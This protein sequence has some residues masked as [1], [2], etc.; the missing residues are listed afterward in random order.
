MP[1]Q[2][3]NKILDQQVT[4]SQTAITHLRKCVK[5]SNQQHM[6]ATRLTDKQVLI[7]RLSHTLPQ[8]PIASLAS[9]VKPIS[10]LALNVCIPNIYSPYIIKLHIG[11]YSLN[12]ESSEHKK[13]IAISITVQLSFYSAE[14]IIEQHELDQYDISTG[15][16]SYYDYGITAAIDDYIKINQ[17]I[18]VLNRIQPLSPNILSLIEDYYRFAYQFNKKYHNVETKLLLEGEQYPEF[19][20]ITKKYPRPQQYHTPYSEGNKLGNGVNQLLATDS[21]CFPYISTYHSPQ[22][23]E[24]FVLIK[25]VIDN[26]IEHVSNLL[27]ENI[28]LIYHPDM[29]GNLPIEIALTLEY[30]DITEILLKAHKYI[31]QNYCNLGEEYARYNWYKSRYK[32]LKTDLSI[33]SFFCFSR[34]PKTYSFQPFQPESPFHQAILIGDL[35]LVKALIQDNPN[36]I[37]EKSNLGFDALTV[38]VGNNHDEITKHLLQ[39]INKHKTKPTSYLN[40][41]MNISVNVLDTAQTAKMYRLLLSYKSEPNKTIP[42]LTTVERAL[43]SANNT[44]AEIIEVMLSYDVKDNR[45]E[46]GITAFETILYKLHGTPIKDDGHSFLRTLFNLF[47]QFCYV[48]NGI[49]MPEFLLA[50]IIMSDV[51]NHN[52]KLQRL[53][54]PSPQLQSIQYKYSEE[55]KMAYLET[56]MQGKANC[57]TFKCFPSASLYDE[58]GK[59]KEIGK[60][61]KQAFEQ[62]AFHIFETNYPGDS[63]FATYF[64]KSPDTEQSQQCTYIEIGLVNNIIK[65]LFSFTIFFQENKL[66]TRLDH[67]FAPPRFEVSNLPFFSYRWVLALADKYPHLENITVAEL[68]APGYAYRYFLNETNF[69]PKYNIIYDIPKIFKI[70]QITDV[71]ENGIKPA[72]VSVTSRPVQHATAFPK[73]IEMMLKE[74]AHYLPSRDQ[75]LCVAAHNTPVSCLSYFNKIEPWGFTEADID[76]TSQVLGL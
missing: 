13:T 63:Y 56:V 2:K 37:L 9:G 26:D 4:G 44:Y 31:Q 57:V 18:E 25:A 61:F 1:L 38:A 62:S 28:W 23:D 34:K 32:A 14:N 40:E 19:V 67:V 33:N 3:E 65:S 58:S 29:R 43:S 8:H 27:S 5:Q 50:P 51:N 46:H 52:Q 68:V 54:Q 20:N 17:F 12:A 69:F 71:D 45:N 39:T 6:F 15:K 53:I 36:V 73:F 60:Q 35:K 48:R 49:F 47:L 41:I 16:I 42:L 10:C 11:A 76:K 64:P 22:S 74:F 72:E 55:D 21:Y 66:I 24:H 7:H 75:E 70:A 59:L 30:L